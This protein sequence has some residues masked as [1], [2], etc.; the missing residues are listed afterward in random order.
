MGLS[1]KKIVEKLKEINIDLSMVNVILLTHEHSDHI[2]GADV[3]LKTAE[4]RLITSAGTAKNIKTEYAI[5]RVITGDRIALNEQVT[6]EIVRASHDASDAIGFIFHV[7]EKRFVHITDTGYI[8]N[9]NIEKFRGAYS[10][11][12][13]SNYEEEVL[14]VNDKY[15]FRVK[16]RILSEVGHMSNIECHQ[17]LKDNISGHTKFVQFAHLSENNNSPELVEQLN[18]SLQVAC[19]TVLQKDEIVEVTLCK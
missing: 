15:P 9:E 6:V 1:R 8:L 19:K 18:S 13:E 17:F 4:A 5:D 11:T 14:I 16:Q 2:K 10:Y 12:I 3:L 7:A